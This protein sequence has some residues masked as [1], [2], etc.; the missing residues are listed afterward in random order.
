MLNSYRIHLFAVAL[1]AILA[2]SFNYPALSGKVI[3]QNDIKQHRGSAREVIDIREESGRQILWTNVMFSGMPTY[4]ISAVYGGE[5]LKY[6]PRTI[7]GLLRNSAIGYLFL[8]MIGFYI[9]SNAL[10]IDPKIGMLGAFAY[11]FSTYFIIVLEAG[12]NSKIHAMAY[13]P[14]ILAG[15]IWA[16]R[17]KRLGLGAAVFAL[18]I[19]LELSARHPQMFYYFLFLAFG[20]GIYELIMAIREKTI[21]YFAKATGALL[22]AALIGVATSLPY[23]QNTYQFGKHTIRGKSELTLNKA[24]KTEGLDRDYATAWSYGISETWSLL[25]PN[26][27]GGAT[28]AIQENEGALEAVDP[29]FRQSIA[30]Q[31]AYFGDQPFTSGPVYVGAIIFFLAFLAFFLAKG[32]LKYA[33]L[34]VLLLTI[35]LSWGKN[36][37]GLTNFFLDNVPFYNK[38]RAVASILIVPEIII[39]LLAILS[40][41]SLSAWDK[42]D[43][44]Q[45][46]KLIVG[47]AHSRAKLFYGAT[48]ILLG[49]LL[50]NYLAPGSFNNFLSTQEA[51]QLPQRLAEA[52]FNNTQ[53]NSF[54]ESLEGARQ[55]IFKADVLRSFFFV[56]F[57]ALALFFFQ[58]GSL[59][60]TG[61]LVVLGLLTL[62]DLYSIN[63]RYLSEENFVDADKVGDNYGV[64]PSPA[65]RAIIAQYQQ[66]PYFRT[67]NLTVSPFNDASTSFFHFSIGGYHGAKLKIYQELIEYQLGGE[68]ELLRQS[69]QQGR[70]SPQMFQNF[71]ALNMLNTRY[72]IANPQGAPLENPSRLGNAWLV[73]ETKVVP[74][75]DSEIQAL[76]NFDP[77]QTAILREDQAA[78]LGSLAQ[79]AGNGQVSL[80]SYDPEELS[81]QYQSNTENLVVFSE[82]WYPENWEVTIDG[83]AAELLRVNYTL[84]GVKVPAGKHEIKMSYRDSASGTANTIAMIASLLVLLGGASLIFLDQKKRLSGGAKEA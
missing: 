72:I 43:W 17:Q 28:S 6:V 11:G 45:S 51:E 55:S 21:A 30:G 10:K 33:L 35:A 24:N 81:Y 34:A 14:G 52:G 58:K 61:L 49:F 41:S 76:A 73:K 64:Q 7:N 39:P 40:L 48:G 16:Y 57:G 37:P 46:V 2:A 59:K 12:H 78:K 70:F 32:Y 60:T 27:K 18:F 69:L 68:I 53:A 13:L 36:L 31:N 74:D 5:L 84:R 66:D 65:D 3:N 8:L 83:Q 56:L 4:L 79:G 63:K 47:G 26:F 1:F 77:S 50:L 38:F 20:Y 42:K 29:R 23:L 54:I 9:L 62:A 75:A 80:T 15:M 82:V 22:V 71:S 25:I 19:G 44:Q 67:L